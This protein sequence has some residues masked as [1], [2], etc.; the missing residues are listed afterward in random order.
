MHFKG[1]KVHHKEP[2]ETIST[3]DDK[4]QAKKPPAK[5]AA[6]V[7]EL[8]PEEEA[9]LK[10]EKARIEALNAENQKR[11]NSMTPDQQFFAYAEDPKK[12]FRIQFPVSPPEADGDQPN[13][14]GVQ[15]VTLD[16]AGLKKLE[17]QINRTKGCFIAFE[18]VVPVVAEEPA[19]GKGAKGGK[20]APT[21]ELKP[22]FTEAWID[23]VPFMY[24]GATETEQRIF[25]HPLRDSELQKMEKA[26]LEK[27]AEVPISEK[28]KKSSAEQTHISGPST[29][30]AKLMEDRHS[31]ILIKVSLSHALNPQLDQQTLPRATD[32]A[33]KAVTNMPPQ[34]PNVFDAVHDFQN[35]IYAVVQ[36]ISI[37]YSRMFSSEEE[38]SPPTINS[39]LGQQQQ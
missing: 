28:D 29:E 34:F 30:E 22:V 31:Y 14:H 25:L 8:S 11:W 39:S 33:R 13:N 26:A 21:D 23:L 17:K 1:A 3:I 16:S 15:E 2:E 12:E 37:E 4:S 24:P 27:L 20:A 38:Q 5:G 7:E 32:I 18:K 9:R 6:K 35:S 19:K 36:E 10:E